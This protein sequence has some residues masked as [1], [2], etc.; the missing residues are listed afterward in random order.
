M[1]GLLGKFQGIDD[2]AVNWN[3]SFQVQFQWDLLIDLVGGGLF[4][5]VR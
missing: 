5:D 1:R 2:S 3:A 4:S